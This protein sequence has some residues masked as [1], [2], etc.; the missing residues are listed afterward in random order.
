MNV[1]LSYSTLSILWLFFIASVL[2]EGS[3]VVC[4]SK[5]E[6]AQSAIRNFCRL[7]TNQHPDLSLSTGAVQCYAQLLQA[8]VHYTT[9]YIYVAHQNLKYFL[10]HPF[11]VHVRSS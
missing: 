2:E 11:R 9:N 1:L 4:S 3:F 7:G 10:V 8:T 6:L 5:Q